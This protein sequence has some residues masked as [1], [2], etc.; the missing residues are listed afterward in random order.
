MKSQKSYLKLGIVLGVFAALVS[1]MCIAFSYADVN[2][3]NANADNANGQAEAVVGGEEQGEAND[4]NQDY[5]LSVVLNSKSGKGLGAGIA[6]TYFD[7][8]DK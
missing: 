6:V 5:T 4:A 8:S 1:L 7:R 3:V 2:D